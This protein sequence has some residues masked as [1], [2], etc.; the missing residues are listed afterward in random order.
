ML[1][2]LN[3]N[4]SIAK[5]WVI[6]YILILN[7]ESISIKFIGSTLYFNIDE[8]RDSIERLYLKELEDE[9][10]FIHKYD[11]TIKIIKADNKELDEV[12]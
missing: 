12:V 9:K 10:M 3:T 7:T 5:F 6:K 4:S 8:M 11:D 1:N 2:K